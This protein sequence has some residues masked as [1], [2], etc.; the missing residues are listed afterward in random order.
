VTRWVRHG[1][2]CTRRCGRL[3]VVHFES[4]TELR[5]ETSV[6]HKRMGTRLVL[7]FFLNIP[8]LFGTVTLSQSRVSRM[9]IVVAIGFI[10]ANSGNKYNKFP[11][12]FLSFRMATNERPKFR[13]TTVMNK[14]LLRFACPFSILYPPYSN[15]PH[16]RCR[17][18]SR[19]HGVP[20][21]EEQSQE[22]SRRTC[23]A[24]RDV[25]GS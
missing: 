20:V 6:Y 7:S 15:S 12:H 18:F 10:A 9:F 24:A 5:P 23:E 3:S 8:S 19:Q 4:P 22:T 13:K 16:S 14:C 1:G 2:K 11:T 25:Y 17:N 21:V